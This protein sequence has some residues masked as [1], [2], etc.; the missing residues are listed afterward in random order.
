MD[1]KIKTIIILLLTFTSQFGYCLAPKSALNKKT[2]SPYMYRVLIHGALEQ[3]NIGEI[4]SISELSGGS[5]PNKPLLFTT[6]TGKF[7]LKPI[8]NNVKDAKY[9]TSLTA[10]LS[11][12]WICINKIVR[13]SLEED[14][15]TENNGKYYV[16]FEYFENFKT[17]QYRGVD[18]FETGKLA[19]QIFNCSLSFNPEYVLEYMDRAKVLGKLHSIQYQNVL[20][21]TIY[22]FNAIKKHFL[23]SHIHNDLHYQNVDTNRRVIDIGMA[24]Y[25][26]RINEFLNILF[27]NPAQKELLDISIMDIL[28]TI[29]GY[30]HEVRIKLN[31]FEMKGI[32]LVLK[33]RLFEDL[34]KRNIQIYDISKFELLEKIMQ[35]A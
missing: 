31:F 33:S 8:A 2:V 29:S 13:T 27:G 5:D 21:S 4:L 15:Y 7:V 6:T 22:E 16:L 11:A 23:K 3:Y 25:N 18:F 20:D 9:F 35:A 10:H 24:Q 30:N 14:L 32:I 34:I 26:Y 28:N 1:I 19:A 17:Q 12:N